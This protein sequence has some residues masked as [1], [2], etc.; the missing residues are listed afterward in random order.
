MN[1]FEEKVYPVRKLKKRQNIAVGNLSKFSNRVYS[2][3]KKIPSGKVLT[4]KQVALKLGDT[5]LARAVGN[6]LNKNP[7]KEV[8]CHRVIKSD[9]KIGGYARGTKKKIEILKKEGVKIKNGMIFKNG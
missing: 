3:V 8:P 7:Y 1:K 5:K 6:A 9:G 4:Y 2:V